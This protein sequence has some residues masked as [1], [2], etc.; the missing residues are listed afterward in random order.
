MRLGFF[1]LKAV[2]FRFTSRIKQI[3][4]LSFP[5]VCGLQV[6]GL[7][8]GMTYVSQFIAMFVSVKLYNV[9]MDNLHLQGMILMFAVGSALFG[10]FCVTWLVETHRRTLDEIEAEFAGKSKVY[11]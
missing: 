3:F 5:S 6:R 7:M 9:L 8:S 4:V 1:L 2:H 11:T 10:S